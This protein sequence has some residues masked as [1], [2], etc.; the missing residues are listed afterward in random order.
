S[1][2]LRT[3]LNGGHA[4]DAAPEFDK[5]VMSGGQRVKGL[6]RRR[7]AERAVFEGRVPFDQHLGA[8]LDKFADAALADTTV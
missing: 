7:G 2:T 4:N 3:L 6:I 8:A 5:W 1:S